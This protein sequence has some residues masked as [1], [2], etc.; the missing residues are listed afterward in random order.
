MPKLKWDEVGTRLFETGT[1]NGAL[2]LQK[3][4]GTYDKPVAWTGLRKVT[5]QPDGAEETPLFADD[6]KYL[7]LFSAE[8]FKGTIGAYTYPDEFSLANGEAEIGTGVTIGQQTRRAFA[9][10]YRTVLGNDVKGNNYGYKLHVVYGV[11]VQP[12]EKEYESVNDDPSAVEFEWDF[13]TTP[14]AVEGYGATA[15][16]VVDSTTVPADKMKALEAALFGDDATEGKLLM[17]SEIIAITGA[18]PEP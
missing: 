18:T 16:V 4:D 3:E 10:V 11:R 1:R 14:V 17:P 15:T 7:S 5:E 2:Y 13:V 6:I 9:F 12:S 8:N